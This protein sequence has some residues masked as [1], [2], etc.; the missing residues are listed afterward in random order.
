MARRKSAP[1]RR[2]STSKGI[3][4]LNALEGYLVANSVTQGLFGEDPIDFF[5]AGTPFSQAK[6]SGQGSNVLTLKEIL[7][8]DDIQVSR[9]VSN[10][11]ASAIGKP[12]ADV[13]AL[14]IIS[15]NFKDNWSTMLW[16]GVLIPAG[17]N[18]A[19]KMTRK[20][21]AQANKAARQLG[22]GDYIKV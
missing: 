5:L 18:V 10:N 12:P 22:L 19:K 6:V 9:R 15:Q 16:Q 13:T 3:N 7:T 20:S 2:R 8:W 17:F 14:D 4:I 21:R 11:V 1:K